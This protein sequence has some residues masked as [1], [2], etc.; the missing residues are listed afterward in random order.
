[1]KCCEEFGRWYRTKTTV[2]TFRG[3]RRCQ[4]HLVESEYGAAR[5]DLGLT[6]CYAQKNTNGRV[7]N[8]ALM[9]TKRKLEERAYRR[10]SMGEGR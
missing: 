4:T 7:S 1:V 10:V 2:S 5:E 6:Y 9:E 8:R 3:R